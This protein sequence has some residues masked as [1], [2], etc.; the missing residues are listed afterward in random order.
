[1]AE[2]KDQPDLGPVEKARDDGETLSKAEAS[3]TVHLNEEFVEEQGADHAQALAS[4][5]GEAA[6]SHGGGDF[7]T[8]RDTI[9]ARLDD[10]GVKLSPVEV[11]RYAE[12]IHRGETL[13]VAPPTPHSND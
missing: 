9:A 7:D 4:V 5:L 8:L 6:A 13:E 2:F 3:Q 11:D 10:A 12:R 1:M